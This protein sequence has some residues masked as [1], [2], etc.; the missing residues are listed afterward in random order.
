MTM[1]KVILLWSV[2]VISVNTYSSDSNELVKKN[3]IEK[4]EN[5]FFVKY[6]E[7]TKTKDDD[8][9]IK[10]TFFDKNKTI[11]YGTELYY[12]AS[13]KIFYHPDR[14]SID[15]KNPE[16]AFKDLERKFNKKG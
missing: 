6:E 12:I 4:F 10:T 14:G 3:G 5:N 2:I 9:L 8:Y 15:I 11:Y 13:H 1:Y 16:E 7:K